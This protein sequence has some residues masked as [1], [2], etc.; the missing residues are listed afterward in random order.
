MYQLCTN[1]QN[2]DLGTPSWT[3][4]VP[5]HAAVRP[6]P[7][8]RRAASGSLARASLRSLLRSIADQV[9]NDWGGIYPMVPGHEVQPRWTPFPAGCPL[10]SIRTPSCHR[11]CCAAVCRSWL[12]VRFPWLTSVVSVYPP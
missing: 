10:M 2:V 9:K 4:C 5:M 11:A 12:G 1:P 8:R 6:F 7:L 3:H